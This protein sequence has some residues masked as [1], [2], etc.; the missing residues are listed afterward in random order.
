MW[1]Q[2]N[3]FLFYAH[4]KRKLSEISDSGGLPTC[5]LF[6]LLSSE[7]QCKV[8]SEAKVLP[9]HIHPYGIHGKTEAL[10][11]GS[12]SRL[13]FAFEYNTCNY[14]ALSVEIPR[15]SVG[16]CIIEH[17]GKLTPVRKWINAFSSEYFVQKGGNFIWVNYIGKSVLRLMFNNI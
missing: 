7:T 15:L 13:S 2:R 8:W 12:T 16:I 10:V 6:L 5:A 3:G 1:V 9:S 17:N 14:I 4:S 11:T